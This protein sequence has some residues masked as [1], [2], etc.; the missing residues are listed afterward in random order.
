MDI[1]QIKS[2]VYSAGFVEDFIENYVT[3]IP[4]D[5]PEGVRKQAEELSSAWTR[6]ERA[7]M[8]LAKENTALENKITLARNAL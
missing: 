3:S 8:T 6:V 1:N 7:L 4:A 2:A 5:A